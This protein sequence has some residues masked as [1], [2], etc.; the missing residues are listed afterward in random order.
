MSGDVLY[1][2]WRPPRFADV[3][4]QE[5]ITRTLT[6]A[7]AGDRTAHAYLL[8]GPRGT[9]KTS[10]ARVLAKALNCTGRAE[11]AGDP[12]GSCDACQAIERGNFVDLIEIDA[13][14]NRGIDE[15]RDLREKVRFSPLHAR[16]K[17]YIIDEAHALTND[18]FNAFLKTL[19]EPP[20]HTVF[21][22]ATTA[23][24]RLPATIVSRCQR[25][26]FHRIASSAVV[27]RL[28]HIARAEG[29]DVSPEVL[30][31]VARAAGGSLRDATNLLDQLITSFGAHVSIEQVRELLGLG[32]EERA[33]ALVKH[34]LAGSTAPAL[35]VINAAAAEG[36]DLRPLHQMTVDFLRAAL[37]LKTGVRDA[38]DLSKEALGD[39]SFA[40][41]STSMEHILRALR[42]FG[43]VSLRLDQPSPLQLELATV[44][45]G[46]APEPAPAR[47][48][49]AI[50][51]P[52]PQ[53]TP[54]QRQPAGVAP[55][56][57]PAQGQPTG[58]APQP[59]PSAPPRRP[60]PPAVQPNAAP[61]YDPSA[62]IDQ[63]LAALWPTILRN[64]THVP[65]KRFNVSA[66]LRSSSKHE[67]DGNTL[68]V[69]FPHQSNRERLQD[70]LDD[71]RCLREVEQVI[72]RELG[73]GVSLRIESDDSKSAVSRAGSEP[74][75][76][77]RAAIDLGAH[78]VTEPE[79][80][81]SRPTPNGVPPGAAQA[82]PQ[83]TAEEAPRE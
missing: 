26:D 54:A 41:S 67:I 40:A 31:T 5:P 55:Q 7:V 64:L 15:M 28:E 52:A 53:Q 25:F 61:A 16:V 8:C 34:L 23:P 18:A 51:Q 81:R 44:E 11:G 80:V 79:P 42:L 35:E 32:G 29:V 60:E 63:R 17:V 33:L 77:V 46:I 36:L 70:E 69:R 19:E 75:H 73:T 76:L 82:G 4:G 24:H 3:V 9:G 14:S 68:V 47:Q 6:Q 22:L 83:P 13:A 56:Q 10:T 43:Q 71:P 48:A 50:A 59:R 65:R 12:C 38:L 20:P 21:I 57:T 30:R 49:A 37:L 45:L 39:L 1:R 27:E 58:V 2:K 66:L 78:V 72:E 62:P 74:G